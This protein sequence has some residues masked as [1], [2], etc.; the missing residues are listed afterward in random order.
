MMRKT[1]NLNA[2][3]N[4][5]PTV[6]FF[7]SKMNQKEFRIQIDSENCYELVSFMHTNNDELESNEMDGME[8]NLIRIFT[9]V[10][11]VA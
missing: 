11:C 8:K 7:A 5:K 2:G 10:S 6:A 4:N 3:K 9:T 1:G